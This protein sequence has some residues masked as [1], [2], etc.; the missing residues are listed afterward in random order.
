MSRGHA[1]LV[2]SR[3]DAA[4]NE[5]TAPPPTGT[6]GGRCF[7]GNVSD[8]HPRA[9]GQFGDWRVAARESP[10]HVLAPRAARCRSAEAAG[11]ANKGP[12]AISTADGGIAR[13]ALGRPAPPAA[14]IVVSSDASP[15]EA[16]AEH[17]DVG[18][19][20]RP[21]NTEGNSRQFR[22]SAGQC[23]RRVSRRGGPTGQRG[24]SATWTGRTTL[25]RP[26]AM[27]RSTLSRLGAMAPS[28]HDVRGIAGQQHPPNLREAS[29]RR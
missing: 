28:G 13:R 5:T 27:W 11:A 15:V 10:R 4:I 20:G 7:T 9:V 8:E 25:N 12:G 6:I 18:A 26:A 23:G 3:T 29:R 1:P 14:A 22:P 16:S 19:V 17:G 21:R 24:P 2:R